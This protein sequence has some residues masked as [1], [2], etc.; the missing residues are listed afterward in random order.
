MLDRER[1]ES[2]TDRVRSGIKRLIPSA[3]RPQDKTVSINIFCLVI[4]MANQTIDIGLS[5]NHLLSYWILDS[6]Q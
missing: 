1:G 3:L 4:R 5:S 6:I 2:E